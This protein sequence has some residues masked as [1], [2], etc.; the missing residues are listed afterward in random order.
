MKPYMVLKHLAK[1]HNVHLVTFHQGGYP[2]SEKIKAIRD[3]GVNVHPIVL[4]AFKAGIRAVPLTLFAAQPLEIAYYNQPDFAYKVDSLM[5]D[6]DFD[7]VFAFFMRTAEYVTDKKVK[8]ILMA[9]DCR[10]LYQERSYKDSN[11]LLQR[12]VRW[13]E[14]IK[15]R[16]YEPAI[17]EKFDVATFVTVNDIEAMKKINPRGNYRLLTNGT[18]IEKFVPASETTER[19]GVLFAGKLDIWANVLM[20]ERISKRIM[21]LVWQELPDTEFH[22]VGANPPRKIKRMANKRIKLIP[23]VP[24][25]KPYLQQAEVFVHPHSGG[26]GIQNKLIEAMACACPVVTTHTGTQGIP[27]IDGE[28]IMIGESD[29]EFASK[30]IMLLRDKKFAS[31][32]GA[33]ARQSIVENL[34]WEHVFHQTDDIIAEIIG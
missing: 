24:D 3:L 31:I 20:I 5:K 17:M 8:K 13:W 12:L 7:L 32:L 25:M 34:S 26:S 2:S 30:I 9:E 1:N 15:L 28:N 14:V 33:N 16:Q 10:E 6:I 11:N 27:A 23:N 18:D 29:E 19:K 4:D 21:P 22:I